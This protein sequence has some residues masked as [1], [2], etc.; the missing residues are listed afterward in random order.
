MIEVADSSLAQDLGPNAQLY[1]AQ[2]VREYWVV[3]NTA[4]CMS[5]F[6][7]AMTS[8]AC[9]KSKARTKP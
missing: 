8:M 4:A 9:R 7:L 1:A 3:C 5:M 2:G 6:Y